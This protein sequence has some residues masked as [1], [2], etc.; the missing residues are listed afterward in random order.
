MGSM[1]DNGTWVCI[2]EQHLYPNARGKLKHG[3]NYT[4]TLTGSSYVPYVPSILL[5]HDKGLPLRDS[6]W[7]NRSPTHQMLNKAIATLKQD[8]A[9]S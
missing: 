1:D 5:K 6:E 3:L 4:I 2:V 7:V 9:S 8:L